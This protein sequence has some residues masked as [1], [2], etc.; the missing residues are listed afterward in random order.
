MPFT[1][2]T[3]QPAG[4]QAKAG[5]GPMTSPGAPQLFTYRTDDAAATV[6]GAG[7]FNEVRHMLEI[8]D[9]IYRVTVNAATGALVSAGHHVVVDKSATAVDVTDV[10]ALTVTDTD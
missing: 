2:S 9:L 4:G 1:R 3:F 6:D 10:T 5:A 7:Y 8:G